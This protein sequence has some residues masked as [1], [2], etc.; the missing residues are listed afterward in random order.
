MGLQDMAQNNA[1]Q[2]KG[3]AIDPNWSAAEKEQ[4]IAAYHAA[5]KKADEKERLG[6]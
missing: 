6:Q 5:R 2:N 1:L 4:Y 3:M